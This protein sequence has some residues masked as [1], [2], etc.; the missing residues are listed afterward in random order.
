MGTLITNKLVTRGFGAKRVTVNLAGPIV[1]GFGGPPSFVVAALA[2]RPLRLRLGQ[3]GTK[4]RLEQLDEVIIWA[5]LIEINGRPAPVN[6]KGWIRVKLDK[7]RTYASVMVEH[8]ASRAR[9]AWEVIRVT[10]QRW[11]R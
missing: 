10:V 5:K 9:A 4:R 7:G 2:D 3:S 6:V 8:I 11:K 1:Q